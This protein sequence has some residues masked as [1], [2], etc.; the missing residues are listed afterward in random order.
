MLLKA[1]K[2]KGENS[3]LRWIIYQNYLRVTQVLLLA[4]KELQP[5]EHLVRL[6]GRWQSNHLSSSNLRSFRENMWVNACW[7]LLW[8]SSFCSSQMWCTP[9]WGGSALV[10]Q[11]PMLSPCSLLSPGLS[12]AEL[13]QGTFLL[14]WD[15]ML[16][17]LNFWKFQSILPAC[18][19]FSGMAA[20]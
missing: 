6:L 8:S 13:Q 12:F 14:G 11:V 3:F 10:C 7:A 17:F 4:A 16:S 19:S 5:N 1:W 9:C 15:F 2:N 20:S 18:L